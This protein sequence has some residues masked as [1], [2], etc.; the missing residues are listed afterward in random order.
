MDC[1]KLGFARQGRRAAHFD[2]FCRPAIGNPTYVHKLK[3]V[4]VQHVYLDAVL[5]RKQAAHAE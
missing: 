2:F 1:Y 3:T 4:L 5:A